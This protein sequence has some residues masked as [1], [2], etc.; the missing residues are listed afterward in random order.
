MSNEDFWK[1]MTLILGALAAIA[2]W[3]AW[4]AA[5]TASRKRGEALEKYKDYARVE[6][7]QANQKAAQAGVDA[8]RANAEAAKA[9]L[10]L[11]KIREKMKNR[12]LAAEQRA[13]LVGRLR[14]LQEPPVTIL[15]PNAGPET[16]AFAESIVSLF[17]EAKF[18][19]TGTG[20]AAYSV[21]TKA[22]WH[23]AM[24]TSDKEASPGTK[25]IQA[26][27]LEIEIPV[28]IFTGN[29]NAGARGIVF[30]VGAK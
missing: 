23:L 6:I 19:I 25:A 21:P 26:A 29:E 17:G 7:A 2:G 9:N 4:N 8:A 13:R 16:R 14:V 1:F 20:V 30:F 12:S 18:K 27:F 5:R 22:P 10:E 24:I 28:D 11:E 3:F 15:M